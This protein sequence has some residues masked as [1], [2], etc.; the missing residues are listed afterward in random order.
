MCKQSIIILVAI[1][2]QL[3]LFS[4]SITPLTLNI[5]GFTTT[6]NGYSLTIS[7]GETISITNFIAPNGVSLNSGF[8]QNNPP[9]VTGIDEIMSKISSDEVTITPNPADEFTYLNT[10]FIS[11]GQ[12]Q[13]QILDI[14]SKLLFRSQA[15]NAINDRRTK[16]DLSNYPSGLYYVL[17]FFKP[18][19]GNTKTG[20]YKI[21]KL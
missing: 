19:S 15:F 9:I 8:L 17:V 14:G 1:F 4:Q 12:I 18:I 7:T 2:V 13:F 5:A 11:T 3:S 16:I 20:I 6:Q 21:V 10:R